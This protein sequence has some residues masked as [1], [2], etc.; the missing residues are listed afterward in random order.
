MAN[1]EHRALSSIDFFSGESNLQLEYSS[2]ALLR[3]AKK[4][5]LMPDLNFSGQ[6]AQN[7]S[8]AVDAISGQIAF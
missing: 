8:T 7:V 3:F 5:P 2:S 1:R 6:W 4:S